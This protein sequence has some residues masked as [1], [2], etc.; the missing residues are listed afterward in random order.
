MQRR[1]FLLP[2]FGEDTFCFNEL[3][4][5]INAHKY[6]IIHI[7]YRP[8]L[9]HFTFPLITVQQFSR[10]LIRHYGIQPQ[11]K[12]LGHSMGGYFS[13]QIRELIGTEICMIG[14][15]NDPKKVIHV[16]PQFPRITLLAAMTG[17]VKTNLMKKY[18]LGKIKDERVKEV[19]SKIMDNFDNFTDNELALMI[20]M[21]YQ[22]KIQSALPNP[23]RIHDKADRIVAPPDEA[24]IQVPGGHFCLNLHPETVY[25]HMKDFLG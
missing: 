15:F 19:Q 20:E 7:D 4:P 12:L 10:Q 16:L 5:F 11:D 25:K 14:S 1:L 21:N 13:F 3:I 9:D 2:G 17:L 8:V 23:L 18:L 22:P 6:Q 24:Y